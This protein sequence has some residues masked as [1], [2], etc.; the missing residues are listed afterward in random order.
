VDEFVD[1]VTEG[2]MDNIAGE[3]AEGVTEE[4][5]EGT[6]EARLCAAV[7]AGVAVGSFVVLQ[8]R[9]LLYCPCRPLSV[10][11]TH[12]A[13]SPI[14]RS[15]KALCWPFASLSLYRAGLLARIC[16]CFAV[17]HIGPHDPPSLFVT[18]DVVRI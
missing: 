16:I 7:V 1:E 18:T 11:V 4:C 14:G 8:V 13:R 17:L 12:L 9:L 2:S 10:V 15:G 3:A 6:T 5:V